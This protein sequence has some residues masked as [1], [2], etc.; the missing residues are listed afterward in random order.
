MVSTRLRAAYRISAAFSIRRYISTTRARAR[1]YVAPAAGMRKL[2]YSTS[3]RLTALE[4]CAPVDKH[5]RNN[6]EKKTIPYPRSCFSVMQHSPDGR[7]ALCDISLNEPNVVERFVGLRVA[8][9]SFKVRA[10]CNY[11]I[12]PIDSCAA[13]RTTDPS[14]LSARLET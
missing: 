9:F 4:L 10:V 14:D 2:S 12:A 8:C 13:R 1:V 11:F 5:D 3:P 7:F 6:S